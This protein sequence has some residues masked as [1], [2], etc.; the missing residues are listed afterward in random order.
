MIAEILEPSNTP[1]VKFPVEINGSAYLRPVGSLSPERPPSQ[2]G[3]VDPESEAP[4]NAPKLA[5]APTKQNVWG[6]QSTIPEAF[7]TPLEAIQVPPTDQKPLKSQCSQYQPQKQQKHEPVSQEIPQVLGLQAAL[8]AA[9]EQGGLF[10]SNDS[11]DSSNASEH[12]STADLMPA[13]TVTSDWS[14]PTWVQAGNGSYSAFP[15]PAMQNP[16][17]GGDTLFSGLSGWSPMVAPV[18]RPNNLKSNAAKEQQDLIPFH[19]ISHDQE[20][21]G[22]ASLANNSSDVDHLMEL[23]LQP[24]H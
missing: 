10:S 12:W 17:S 13:F 11:T 15:M 22:G 2:D 23:L 21:Y 19:Y 1:F 9:E 5:S 14:V 16:F 8:G 24:Q 6:R 18:V 7:R 20:D 4:L 3:L